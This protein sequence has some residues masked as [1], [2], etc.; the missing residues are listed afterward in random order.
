M[1]NSKPA[2]RRDTPWWHYALPA[3]AAILL[4]VGIAAVVQVYA[5]HPSKNAEV[6]SKAPVVDNSGTQK[7]VKLEPAVKNLAR[8]FIQTA[9][10]RKNLAHAYTLVG[11]QIKQGMTL[12]Q[13]MTGNIAVIPYPA[14]SIAFAPFRI[15]YSYAREALLEVMLLPKAK[16]KIRP[17]DFY[18]GVNKVGTGAKA[19]WV[20]TSWSPH[21]SPMVPSD[22]ANN[23]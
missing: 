19:H 9:V 21:V 15:D 18:L 5:F 23:S 11:P 16:A 22:N 3:V 14:D 13:W 20:V 8:D 6:F 2:R 10:A 17:T 4:I 7:S 1:A 12:K